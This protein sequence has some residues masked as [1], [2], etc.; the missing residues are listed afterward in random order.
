MTCEEFI[1]KN[2]IANGSVKLF[3][4]TLLED[5][6]NSQGVKAEDVITISAHRFNWPFNQRFSPYN[7]MAFDCECGG[8]LTRDMGL[9]EKPSGEYV[10]CVPEFVGCNQCNKT[11]DLPAIYVN[12]TYKEIKV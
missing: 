10:Y 7:L 3:R 4:D 12:G 8:R 1:A 5:H 11:I 9:A 6:S 2:L